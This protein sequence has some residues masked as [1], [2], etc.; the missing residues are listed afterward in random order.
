MSASGDQAD[1]PP[2]SL[3]E[4]TR[5]TFFRKLGAGLAIAVPSL[6][7]LVHA[8]PAN[9]AVCEQVYGVYKG[10]TC[11]PRNSCPVGRTN[12]CIGVWYWYCTCSGILCF[13]STQDEGLCAGR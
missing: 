7:G 9:A 10:H 1:L 4:I 8:S 2:R 5:R 12:H 6:Y 3:P 13:T 11:G